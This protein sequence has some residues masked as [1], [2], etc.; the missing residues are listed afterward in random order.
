M[1]IVLHFQSLFSDFFLFDIILILCEN[2]NRIGK[3]F[4]IKCLD[5][6]GAVRSFLSSAVTDNTAKVISFLFLKRNASYPRYLVGELMVNVQGFLKTIRV[7]LL[8]MISQLSDRPFKGGCF[9]C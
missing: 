1:Y 4:L 3:N 9:N 6:R 7:I 5:R 2:K 8:D